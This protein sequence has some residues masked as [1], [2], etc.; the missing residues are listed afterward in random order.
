MGTMTNKHDFDL[1][2]K[3]LKKNIVYS[4]TV[5]FRAD[6]IT[7]PDGHNSVREYIEHP[8]AAAVL[9]LL[10]NGDII[11][12]R[13]YRYPVREATLEIPAGKMHSKQDNPLARAKA[14]LEEETGYTAKT[15]RFLTD[16]WPTCAF[17]DEVLRIY[18]AEGLTPGE[19]HPDEDEFLKLVIL[20]FKEAWN[21]LKKGKIKDSKT[22]IALQALKI[23]LLE[24]K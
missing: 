18:I 16:F 9:P 17:S 4:G 21:M 1:T 23:H 20:P 19:S 7:L 13:Q 14:E 6:D 24:E 2:E 22:I 5:N 10:P 11:F 15:Y 3:I 12:I 8:G